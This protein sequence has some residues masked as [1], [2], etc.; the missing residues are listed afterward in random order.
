MPRKTVLLVD[1]ELPILYSLGNFLEKN[2]F[3][4]K[5]ATD[6]E[7]ALAVF[8]STTMLDL[9]IT[10]LVMPGISGLDV[11]REIKKANSKT[12]VFILTG[13]GNMALSVEK[14][15]E[16]ADD[17]LF[18]PCDPDE[19]IY[20]MNRFFENRAFGQTGGGGGLSSR[21]CSITVK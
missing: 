3:N 18:K 8:R 9:V 12:G 14:L 15:L 19:L 11:L 5:L 10:D 4:V 7:D 13:Y 21:L 17:I 20:K 2:K 1:D 6:G 16:S